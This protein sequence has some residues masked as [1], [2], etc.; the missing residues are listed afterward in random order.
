[1]DDRLAVTASEVELLQVMVDSSFEL[2]ALIGLDYRYLFANPAY[3]KF[4]GKPLSGVIGRTPSEVIGEA[5]FQD[6]ARPLLDRT[7]AGESVA[8]T[9]T[10]DSPGTEIRKANVSFTPARNREGGIIGAVVI[11]RDITDLE[12]AR[13]ALSS[14]QDINRVTFDH[15]AVGIAHVGLRGEWLEVNPRLCE[16]VGY[17]R[18]KLMTLTFQDITHPDDLATDLEHVRGVLAGKELT[19]SMEKRYFRSTGE[20]IWIELTVSLVRDASGNP[21]HFISFVQDIH[22]RKMAELKLLESQRV[23]ADAVREIGDKAV[24]L[25]RFLHV[26]SHD[27]R[28]PLNTIANFAGLLDG[29]DSIARGTEGRKYV[30]YVQSGAG[31]M[32]SL[33]DELAQYVR[34]DRAGGQFVA[35]SFAQVAETVLADLGAQISGAGAGITLQP[36]PDAMGEPNLLRLVLQNLVSNAVKFVAPG[37]KP[38]ISVRDVSTADSGIRI[39]VCDNGIG[40]DADALPALFTPFSQL[41]P[42]RR[43]AGSGLG[44]AICKRIAELHGGRV[45]VT[46]TPGAGSCFTLELPRHPMAGDYA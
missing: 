35:F 1:M 14:S 38:M 40:I 12:Q 25:E 27:L 24:T 34:L 13:S 29:E 31:R 23:L 45:E 39:S 3:L 30:G 33:L 19:Y 32:K 17:T 15:A 26:L 22:A 7:F 10:F 16:I 18:E 11:I 20:T 37:V 44:L 4:W 46:S 41:N 21:A 36:L 43:Y 8:Y 9:A 42:R 5:R 28:E 2:K 6:L